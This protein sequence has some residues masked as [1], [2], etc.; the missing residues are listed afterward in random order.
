MLP[1]HRWLTQK[2]MP[3]IPMGWTTALQNMMED[4][5]GIE[6]WLLALR[7]KC[8]LGHL[9]APLATLLRRKLCALRQGC[10]VGHR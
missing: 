8:L 1:L 10:L 4:E 5:T 6:R 2:R 3:P 9:R 7:Q